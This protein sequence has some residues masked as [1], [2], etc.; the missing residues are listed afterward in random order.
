MNI[1]FAVRQGIAP[2]RL[3][4]CRSEIFRN[5]AVANKS[6]LK[7]HGLKDFREGDPHAD[8]GGRE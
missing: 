3:K 5:F 7:N 4:S 2:R 6:K 1:R 8:C